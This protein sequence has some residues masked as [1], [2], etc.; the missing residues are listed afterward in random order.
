MTVP[1]WHSITI[2]RGKRKLHVFDYVPTPDATEMG[3]RYRALVAHGSHNNDWIAGAANDIW[4]PGMD[5]ID[6]GR[7]MDKRRPGAQNPIPEMFNQVPLHHVTARLKLADGQRVT[8]TT[9]A[10]ILDALRVTDRRPTVDSGDVKAVVSVL[11]SSIAAFVAAPV[12]QR[13]HAEAALYTEICR[14]CT[15]V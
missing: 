10:V 13:R 4:R 11:G 1:R 8:G 3:W 6:F 14:R 7:A 5:P 15:I 2:T 12:E 9:L